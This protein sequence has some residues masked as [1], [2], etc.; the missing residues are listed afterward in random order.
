MFI[1]IL[2]LIV[3]VAAFN[4]G[5]DVGDDGALMFGQIAILCAHFWGFSPRCLGG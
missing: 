4:L 3:A 5:L 1:I 2:T